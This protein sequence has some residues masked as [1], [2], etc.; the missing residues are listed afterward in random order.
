MKLDIY[1]N[2]LVLGLNFKDKKIINVF[3]GIILF[4]LVVYN[5]IVF[6]I[7]PI[8]LLIFI[9]LSFFLL[10]SLLNFI[11]RKIEIENNVIYLS[12]ILKKRKKIGTLSDISSFSLNNNVITVLKDD[13]K[14]FSFS[15]NGEDNLL[16]YNY[17]K[18]NYK[19][20]ICITSNNFF[21]FWII[22]AYTVISLSITAKNIF[23]V[24][25]YILLSLFF[26]LLSIDEKIKVFQ[27]IDDRIIIYKRLFINRSL[28]ISS[29]SKV[30]ILKDEGVGKYWYYMS[31]PYK[32]IGLSGKKRVF[33]IKTSLSYME[34]FKSTLKEY[35]IKCT[36]KD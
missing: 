36:M 10:F 21:L 27:I 24:F 2:K 12:T 30:I 15:I 13:K 19:E 20:S 7:K 31:A 16:F 17:L 33:K 6:F 28:N 34:L 5:I 32:I 9:P 8:L 25:I 14:Y 4:L 22:L 29:L 23:E 11:T 26:L 18:E 1:N 35:K 3:F